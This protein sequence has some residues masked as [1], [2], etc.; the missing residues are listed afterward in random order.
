MKSNKFKLN[1][2]ILTDR[3]NHKPIITDSPQNN[4]LVIGKSITF[5]CS[6]ISDLHLSVQWVFSVCNNCS[7]QSLLKVMVFSRKE[8]KIQN[9]K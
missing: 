8:N 3:V 1:S 7:N 2:F 5:K 4:T 9:T 6:I